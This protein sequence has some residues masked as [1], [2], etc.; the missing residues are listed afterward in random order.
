MKK[1]YLVHC[2]SGKIEDGWYPW[3]KK[4]LE[5]NEIKVIMKNMP[6]TDKPNIKEW[7]SELENIVD[8]ID[9]ET[10]FI[11]HSIGCQTILRY[12][13][14]QEVQKIGGIFFVAPWFDLLPEEMD[15]ESNNI[16]YEWIHEEIDF[17]KIKLFTDNI[18][19]IFSDN[20]YFVDIKQELE[21]KTKLNAKTITLKNK[22]HISEEDGIK[23]LPEALLE[24][25]NMLGLELLDALDE[26]GNKTGKILDKDFIHNNNILHNEVALVI[27]NSKGE[28]LMQK[29]SENKRFNPNK[30]SVCAGHVDAYESLRKAC[31]RETEEEIGIRVCENDLIECG[32]IVK[33]RNTNSHITNIYCIKKDIKIEDCILQEDE[34]SELKWISFNE[35]KTMILNSDP[36]TV[37]VNTAENREMCNKLEKIINN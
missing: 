27:I 29:R 2:W 28:L 18:T 4:H 23:E 19:A 5:N 26:N 12:L 20:D 37:F 30:W 16:A 10:F 32:S 3:I 21:F 13:Q 15:E 22:G 36:R 11:G 6:N 34:V 7:V 17:E 35:F 25:G 31:V 9:D 33:K 1:A 14:K 24:L 8:N